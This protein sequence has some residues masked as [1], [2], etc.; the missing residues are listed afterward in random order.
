[1][2]RGN[3]PGPAV[4]LPYEATVSLTVRAL[5]EIPYLR[6][7]VHAGASGADN[8]VA[9]AHSI[10]LPHPWEWLEAGDLLMTVGLGVPAAA[11][12]QVAYV[13]Q[14][15][16]IGVS[17][18]A[19]GEEM[20]APP[21]TDAML[22]AANRHGLP[23]L[24]TAYE[25]PFVQISRTVAAASQRAEHD[26]LVRAARIYDQVRA[27]VVRDAGAHDLLVGLEDEVGCAL[28]VCANDTGAILAA[29]AAPPA[30]GMV[31]AFREATGARSGALPGILRLTADGRPLL[32]VPVPARRPS[33]LL[34]RPKGTGDPPYALLQHVATVA[35]LQVERLLASREELR[36]LGSETLAHLLDARISP[37][38]AA[39]QLR[40]HG[41][42]QGPYVLV[43]ASRGGPLDRGGELHHVLA[44]RDV[45]NLLLRRADVLHALLPGDARLES[46]LELLR[47]PFRVGVS[48]V[49]GDL[50]AIPTAAREARWAL[51]AAHAEGRLR[52]R[53]GEDAPLFGPRSVA[54][55]RVAVDRVLG[56]L[57]AYDAAHRTE[58]VPSLATF[59]RCNRSWQRA[60]AELFVHKQTLVYRMRRVEEL[61]SR[62][63]NDT[64]DVA[65]L[66]LALTAHASIS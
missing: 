5:T 27:A 54:E 1:M 29:G 42:E 14:L 48:D 11:Q 35:A 43:A 59:L 18:V 46:V 66:W 25:V 22:A 7:R 23:L 55:A 57:L 61:T 30:E 40:A 9:W 2:V 52:V 65:E 8:V 13:E 58:L 41:L 47:P 63:L 17:G 49:F 53:Y 20:Q 4:I 56:P 33:S 12:D 39:V 32:V 50:E 3:E 62:R 64:G 51:A 28:T 6:T 37:A 21:L 60:T 19:I 24:F 34:A 45:P 16:A 36:R 31:T 26:R 15:T 38:S 44:E 10:E